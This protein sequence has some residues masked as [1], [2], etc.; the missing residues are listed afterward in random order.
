MKKQDWLRLAEIVKTAMKNEKQYKPNVGDIVK[1]EAEVME[2]VEDQFQKDD[3]YLVSFKGTPNNVQTLVDDEEMQH[4][5]LVSRPI[6]LTKEQAEAVR[7]K[8]YAIT[9][10]IVSYKGFLDW[11]DSVTEDRV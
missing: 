3:G 5:E 6:R 9:N 10:G 4:A 2:R 1:L 8:A 11:L 7:K